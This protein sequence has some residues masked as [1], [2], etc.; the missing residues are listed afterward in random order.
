M[1]DIGSIA[2]GPEL[3]RKPILRELGRLA[4]AL[5]DTPE[6]ETGLELAFDIPGSLGRADFEGFQLT[7]RR[8]GARNVLVFIEVPEA[9]ATSA[10][11]LAA[12]I[13]LAADAIRLAAPKSTRTENELMSELTRAA[14]TLGVPVSSTLEAT[15]RR[16]TRLAEVSDDE[17]AI[18]IDLLLDDHADVDR[19]FAFEEALGDYLEQRGVGYVD[20]NEVG[21]GL[22]TIFA[23]G[24]NSVAL[25]SA[26]KALIGS[27]ASGVDVRIRSMPADGH[28]QAGDRTPTDP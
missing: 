28:P 19:A 6:T 23:Y 10:E 2:H 27:Q 20:G 11:P 21:D 1:I 7:R 5:Y 12:L 15:D 22:F 3:E 8:S 26:I 9:I 13:D 18:E 16:S 25:E 4:R 24:E 14:A 17:A